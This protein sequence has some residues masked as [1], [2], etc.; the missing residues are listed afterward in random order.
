MQVSCGVFFFLPF[1]PFA[2]LLWLLLFEEVFIK[3]AKPSASILEAA[4]VHLC[5]LQF[6]FSV[7]RIRSIPGH[8]QISITSYVILCH[9]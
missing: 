6:C 2:D 7:D 8:K 5:H 4:S 3:V 1:I 9:A